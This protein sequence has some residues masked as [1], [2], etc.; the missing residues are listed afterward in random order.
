MNSL[1]SIMTCQ[2][3]NYTSYRRSPS[4]VNPLTKGSLLKFIH[5]SRCDI[6][7][8]LQYYNFRVI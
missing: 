1:K 3:W 7:K 6:P 4:A 5:I 2:G 8:F